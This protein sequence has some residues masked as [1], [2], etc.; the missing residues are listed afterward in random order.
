ML[1]INNKIITKETKILN[2]SLSKFLGLMFRKKQTLIF[3]FKKEVKHSIH[4]FFVFFP[5][6]VIF[7]DKNNKI[8][9]T[10]MNLKPFS[11]YFPKNKF[12][13]LIELPK[14]KINNI[15]KEDNISF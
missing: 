4:M 14:G 1:R 13:T 8:I 15:K 2:S 3:K 6:D 10:K 9:E 5:I 7:L 11:I 12:N